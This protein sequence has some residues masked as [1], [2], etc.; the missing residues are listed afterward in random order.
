MSATSSTRDA[1]SAYRERICFECD[2]AGFVPVCETSAAH[3]T[4]ASCAACSGRG[5]VRVFVYRRPPDWRGAWPPREPVFAPTR[6]GN[7]ETAPAPRQPSLWPE[8]A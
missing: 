8:A 4:P 2:G 1:P 3:P 7:G 6:P 5:A